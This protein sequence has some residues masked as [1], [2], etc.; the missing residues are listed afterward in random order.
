MAIALGTALAI[1]AAASAAGSA[2]KGVIQSKAAKKAAQQQVQGTQEASGY[3]RQGMNQ[4]HDLWSPYVNSGAGAM[5]TLSRLTTPGAGAR[6][7]SAGPPNA[8]P[9]SPFAPGQPPGGQAMP[10]MPDGRQIQGPYP[11]AEGGDLMVDRPTMF[12][13]GE[14]GPERA[15][16]S[17]APGG[18]FTGPFGAAAA[19]IGTA[20]MGMGRGMPNAGIRSPRG[21]GFAPGG[22]GG[23]M[24]GAPGP[25]AGRPPG[26]GDIRQMLMQ[27]YGGGRPMGQMGPPRPNPNMGPNAAAWG[28][29]GAAIGGMFGGGP[30]PPM[31]GGAMNSV[32]GFRPPAG[33]G[34]AGPF[35][36]MMAP[37]GGPPPM[38]VP[39][40]GGAMMPPDPR[41]QY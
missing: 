9:P 12:L 33:G 16:F 41:V 5:G 1:G 25:M 23:P 32:G 30:K 4:L 22:P 31:P 37:R 35:G 17:G 19:G 11:M 13:A 26:G 29:A 15:T 21:G 36:G 28:N 18:G 38:A 34:F 20:M 8:M 40:S 24:A 10:R 39:Y 14:A 27:K 7:A 2:A 6:Y 3:M